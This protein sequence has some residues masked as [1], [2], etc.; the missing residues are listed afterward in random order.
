MAK[1]KDR[2]SKHVS[3]KNRKASFEY[4][5]MET[6]TAGIVL[7]GAEI[8]SI[9]EGKVNLSE[10]FGYVHA[11]EIFVKGMHISPY[12]NASF[13]AP[14]PV[15]DRK[16]LLSKREIRKISAK[17]E[18]KGLTLVVVRLYINNRG[19]AKLEIALA[20]GKKLFDKRDSIKDRDTKRDL[21]RNY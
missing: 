21:A 10:A 17:L 6:Y 16:L 11:E 4:H 8:K 12:A 15:R 7:Q 3:I 14:D 19:L 13:N 9:R 18:E 2:F 20:K 5:L 1:E